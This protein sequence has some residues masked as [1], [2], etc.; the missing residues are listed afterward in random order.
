VK[1]VRNHLNVRPS[2]QHRKLRE[3]QSQN[4]MADGTIMSLNGKTNDML[5][6]RD[7]KSFTKS[8]QVE[9]REC[10]PEQAKA[11]TQRFRNG[12]TEQ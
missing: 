1:E 2:T 7:R 10:E 5:D 4:K 12:S 8:A 11:I 3:L 6:M 9:E